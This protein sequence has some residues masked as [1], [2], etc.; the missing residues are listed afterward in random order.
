MVRHQLLE[1]DKSARVI[2]TSL[3]VSVWDAYFMWDRGSLE[4]QARLAS[5]GI[6]P[7]FRGW[8]LMVC[9]TSYRS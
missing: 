1:R 3:G 2:A 6:V 5:I 4:D 9:Y 8:T 7:S